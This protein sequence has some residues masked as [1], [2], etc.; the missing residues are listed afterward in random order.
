MSP[1]RHADALAAIT[2]PEHVLV[3]APHAY[4]AD[5]TAMRGLEGQ[6]DAV[7]LPASAEQVA[8]VVGY[9]YANDVP[10][11]PRGGGSGFAAGAVPDGGIVLGLERMARVRSFDPLLW[12]IEVEAGVPT[13]ELHRLARESGLRFPP[14]P[15]AGEQSLVGGNIATNAGGPHAFK[16]GTTGAWVAGLEAV[17]PP[18]EV[19]RVGGPVRKDVAGYDLKGLLIGSEG[20]LGIVTAAWL[21]LIPSAEA[22]LPVVGLF[23]G[24]VDGCGAIE[25]AMA[26]GIVPAAIEYLDNGTMAAAGG[27]FPSGPE[28]GF[29]VIAEADG[30]VAEAEAGREAL[31]EAMDGAGA[32]RIVEPEGE[33]AAALW[34]WR[35]GVSLRVAAKRGGKL[36]EDI[37]VPLDRLAEAIQGTLEIGGRHDVEALSWGHAGDGNLHSS[38]LVAPG[39]DA[40]HARAERACEELFELALSLG[41]TITGEHGV[42]RVKRAYL[43]R[44]LGSAARL[45]TEI[46][47]AFD[48]KGLLNPGVKV[49]L[50]E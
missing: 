37:A 23:A 48:P 22:A 7:V 6:A 12:R 25:A 47:R 42:G 4:L 29:A 34:R 16:Y 32:R 46:K 35:D 1:G 9:C 39:N 43:E 5:A 2:G 45:N 36:S 26:S 3:P 44:Q 8:A 38:F 20:T 21:R 10:I 31:R 19:I 50:G 30:T 49:C 11:T 24:A 40:E 41:G 15:G 28:Q 18:G 13:A 33:A 14:D 27:A 17:I